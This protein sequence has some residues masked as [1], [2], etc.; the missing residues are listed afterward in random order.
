MKYFTELLTPSIIFLTEPQVFECDVSSIFEPMKATHR[1][2]LNSE[3][4]FNDSLALEKSKAQGG[5]M[6]VWSLSIDPY[7]TIMPT[8]T[9]AILPCMLKLPGLVTSYHFCIYLPTAGQNDQFVS[10]L[11]TLSDMISEI[12]DNSDGPSPSKTLIVISLPQKS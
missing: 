12:H 8:S 10:T 3:D 4:V 2:H 7:V 1:F 11:A 6:L 5:T 9:S